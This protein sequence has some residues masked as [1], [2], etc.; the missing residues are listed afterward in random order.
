[1]SK[2]IVRTYPTIP[3]KEGGFEVRTSRIGRRIFNGIVGVVAATALAIGMAGCG[4]EA[5]AAEQDETCFAEPDPQQRAQL[6]QQLQSD[7]NQVSAAGETICVIE[8]DGEKRYYNQSD[9]YS[10][11]MLYYFLFGRSQPLLA[12]GY[13]SGALDPMD[14]ILL[15][16]LMSTDNTG[17]PY[18]LYTPMSDGGWD[19]K[20]SY[21]T[22]RYSNVTVRTVYYGKNPP[23]SYG[24][25][26]S[27]V[28]PG[29]TW[30][31]VPKR[32]DAIYTRSSTGQ[33]TTKNK[34]AEKLAKKTTPIGGRTYVNKKA[35]DPTKGQFKNKPIGPAGTGPGSQTNT[36]PNGSYPNTQ[37]GGPQTGSNT[38]TKSKTTKTY[39]KST[40]RK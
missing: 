39:S 10:D 21:P 18:N 27:K 40:K 6:Q 12:Y 24:D 19:R 2:E 13:L 7:G 15:S 11:F 33:V 30:R 32:S 3:L 17:R 9:G 37:V 20:R 14:V 38:N 34:G 28:P 25:S 16:M 35:T 1:V 31:A 29:Y 23:V 4:G 5:E 8:E 26:K 22:G 36:G